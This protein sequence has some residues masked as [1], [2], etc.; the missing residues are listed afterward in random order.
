MSDKEKILKFCNESSSIVVNT[1]LDGI[2]CAALIRK[3]NNNLEI[4]GFTDSHTKLFY[5]NDKLINDVDYKK[6]AL[7]LDL[8]VANSS[9]KCI[10]QHIVSFDEPIEMENKINPNITH[11]IGCNKYFSKYP[12]STSLYIL[13]LLDNININ[14]D[15]K[16]FR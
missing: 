7:F 15:K 1:D 14:Y 13:F 10:D 12:F 2:F 5:I 4:S 16:V 6:N 8:Y 11:K 3:I 9:I